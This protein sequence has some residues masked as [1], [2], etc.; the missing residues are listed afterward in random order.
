[1]EKSDITSLRTFFAQS[2]AKKLLD[3]MLPPTCPGC[4]T[5]VSPPGGLCPECWEKITFISAPTCSTCGHP[6]EFSG[7]G[8]DNLKGVICGS[9][10]RTPPPF[11][12]ARAAFIYNDASRKMVLAFKH[13]DQT[14]LAGLFAAM[15]HRVGAELINDCDLII[16][17]PISTMKLFSRRYN[18]SAEIARVLARNSAKAFAPSALKRIST[19]RGK[20][21][22]QANLSRRARFENVRGVF[23]VSPRMAQ[24][25]KGK[26]VLLVDDVLTTGATITEAARIIVRAGAKNV[27]VL[28]LALVPG[29]K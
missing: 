5:I 11:G 10:A 21:S 4:K 3:V 8:E 29:P 13:A 19:P 14:H 18:Q 28:T 6:F 16:P 2:V 27:D 24:R 22:S 23:I 25:L 26:S 1:M 9:C 17:I 20:K 12:R 15:L 7:M